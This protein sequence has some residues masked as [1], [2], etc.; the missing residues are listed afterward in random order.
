MISFFRTFLIADFDGTG[1][2]RG[3]LLSYSLMMIFSIFCLA[4]VIFGIGFVLQI[5]QVHYCIAGEYCFASEKDLGI[6]IEIFKHI[7]FIMIIC[8]MFR[9]NTAIIQR[10]SLLDYSGIFGKIFFLVLTFIKLLILAFILFYSWN[11]YGFFTGEIYYY[12][13]DIESQ[14]KNM[15]GLV[16]ILYIVFIAEIF[17]FLLGLVLPKLKKKQ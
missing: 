13:S 4:S 1:K 12:F 11:L 6:K 14:A 2:T 3:N 8:F 10:F 9:L 17:L 7:L 16:F 15:F 5:L